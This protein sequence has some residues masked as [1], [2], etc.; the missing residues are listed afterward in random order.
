MTLQQ[1][2]QQGRTIL[3]EAGIES[4]AFDAMCLFRRVFSV[5][6]QTLLLHGERLAPLEREQEFLRLI[7]E[8]RDGRPLQYILGE[9]EFLGMSLSVGEGVLIPREETELLVYT[10]VELLNGCLA[11]R[12]VDLCAGTGAVGLG[13]VSLLPHAR[14]TC[15]ERYDEALLYLQKNCEVFG[16]NR[17]TV[18]CGDAFDPA[19]AEPY[20]ALDAFVSNP[21]YI[22]TAEL[23]VLQSEVQKEPPTA[24]DGGSDGLEFYRAI[25]KLWLP[26]LR[27]G[28]VAAVEIGESQG[29][30][31][32]RLFSA[33]GL[34][35]IQI[36]RD[37]NG[38][39]RV[40]CGLW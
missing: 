27:P 3:K 28:G 2:Y 10:A 39:D 40:V 8:R 30:Q 4:P 26:C 13:I 18:V 20:H 19:A 25:A 17:V 6:R 5:D 35:Q 12:V 32:T 34:R 37:F 36:L 11:P 9:W 21:P 31:V 15:I 29:A 23:A 1:V 7:K 16:E 38:L 33:A 14:V 24:L 22:G